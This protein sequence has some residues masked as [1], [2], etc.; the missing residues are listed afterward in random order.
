MSSVFQEVVKGVHSR[1][2]WDDFEDALIK[3]LD[4]KSLKKTEIADQLAQQLID[5]L[6]LDEPEIVLDPGDNG[7]T[8]N[9]IAQSIKYACGD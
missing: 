5:D 3:K 4:D 6:T 1:T 9:Y 2:N 7:D 8:I